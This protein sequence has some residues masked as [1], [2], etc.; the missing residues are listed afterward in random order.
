MIGGQV[1]VLV[2]LTGVGRL[3]PDS[4]MPQIT[5]MVHWTLIHRATKIIIVVHRHSGHTLEL[6]WT[7]FPLGSSQAG[8]N[9]AVHLNIR[10]LPAFRL[11]ASVA[12]N[13]RLALRS[14]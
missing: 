12:Q 7:H 13:L 2:V 1:V 14:Q 11:S 8:P 3:V 9:S 4:I 6:C 5:C 10:C